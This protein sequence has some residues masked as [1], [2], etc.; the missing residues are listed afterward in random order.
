M[1]I[2]WTACLILFCALSVKSAVNPSVTMTP[3]TSVETLTD[4]MI[5]VPISVIK[6][7]DNTKLHSSPFTIGAWVRPDFDTQLDG[8][9]NAIVMS[10]NNNATGRAFAGGVTLS[11]DYS[12]KCLS[13]SGYSSLDIPE[14]LGSTPLKNKEWQYISLSFN[15]S[16][17]KITA[18]LNGVQEL[19]VKY[20]DYAWCE[21]NSPENLFFMFG[22]VGYNGA[23]DD[24]HISAKVM[25]PDQISLC[26][27]NKA[28]DASLSGW[29]T[30]DEIADG[31]TGEFINNVV[32]ENVNAQYVT[33]QL[34][35]KTYYSYKKETA[36]AATPDMTSIDEKSQR[37]TA[38]TFNV[39]LPDASYFSGL[40]SLT[41]SE[42]DGIVLSNDVSLSLEANSEIFINAEVENGMHLRSISVKD[43]EIDNGGS[44][45]VTS[46]L[47]PSDFNIITANIY[48]L[49]VSAP[50]L[51]KYVINSDGIKV[52]SPFNIPEG[53]E[54]EIILQNTFLFK[55]ISMKLN[56]SPITFAAD[57]HIH[58]TM[59]QQNTIF[60]F[61]G[62]EAESVKVTI[63]YNEGGEFSVSD[64]MQEI[65]DN[66]RVVPGTILNVNAI[67]AEGYYLLG[68]K[69]NG[70]IVQGN[71]VVVPSNNFFIAADFRPVEDYNKALTFKTISS[72][73]CAEEDAIE[74]SPETIGLST[75]ASL[76]NANFAAGIWLKQT[77][78]INDG[79]M[80]LL[81]A[82]PMNYANTNP[83]L[84]FNTT[85]E[86][87]L[88]FSGSFSKYN[89]QNVIRYPMGKVLP[90]N[91]WHHLL[92]NVDMSQRRVELYYDG[93]FVTAVE[94]ITVPQLSSQTAIK[95]YGGGLTFNGAFDEL[96][97]FNH[98][99][100]AEDIT[101]L[102][103]GN[104][105]IA[106]LTA[107]YDFQSTVNGKGTFAN[108]IDEYTDYKAV[109]HIATGTTVDNGMSVQSHQ[110]SVADISSVTPAMQRLTHLQ[111]HDASINAVA[112][113]EGS[114]E[115]YVIETNGSRPLREGEKIRNGY[116]LQIVATPHGE[117]ILKSLKI[118]GKEHLQSRAGDNYAVN[119]IVNGD[120]EIEASF[121]SPTAAIES[122][123]TDEDSDSS[124][125]NDSA[126][127]FTVS[128]LRIAKPLVPGIYIKIVK[129]KAYK[130]I[131]K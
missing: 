120:T 16:T 126:T 101:K 98:S 55:N 36:E 6:G 77:Q 84:Y 37:H 122:L 119:H 7:M 81:V 67:P 64:G 104:T 28:E 24:I 18:Y 115:T 47:S 45:K 71:T 78:R 96:Q 62:E 9:L 69:V 131:K 25:T 41:F 65:T 15:P 73:V 1:R 51:L 76:E 42:K 38:T 124:M 10:A 20:T 106:S 30:L 97:L 48:N 89:L 112:V 59:P 79:N 94:N 32:G 57:G 92:F 31:T 60:T 105:D 50:D 80:I 3:R 74:L 21:S 86:G 108:L 4:D 2:L 46:D 11:I 8:Q 53:A 26:M 91:E 19:S 66:D 107:I 82:T 58:F 123:P 49:T 83:Y 111:S 75:I 90:L 54:V 29:Y 61:V 113:G 95:L 116:S 102:Y 130:V 129:N 40:K 117:N 103:K 121:G 87:E 63:Q 44:F 35:S 22:S 127:Y 34:V 110:E 13:V 118:N 70:D 72:I 114:I 128:G 52:A 100:S 125:T 88:Q 33:Y 39:I 17:Q 109:Y 56:D 43:E 5:R 93:D 85:A 14:N 12:T 99:L 68:I 27:D 23:I